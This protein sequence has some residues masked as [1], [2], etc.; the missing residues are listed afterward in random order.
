MSIGEVLHQSG[1]RHTFFADWTRH[2]SERAGFFVVVASRMWKSIL[3]TVLGKVAR[4]GNFFGQFF[5]Q[6]ISSATKTTPATNFTNRFDAIVPKK[7]ERFKLILPYRP[8][9]LA[10]RCQC[11]NGKLVKLKP[12]SR[13]VPQFFT[14]RTA[15]R[16]TV[17][18][19]V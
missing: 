2:L 11:L 9:C 1:E 13:A 19:D 4:T 10:F 6:E 8:Y 15:Y 12:A 5:G 16:V 18:A 3:A 7:Q 17:R 14:A